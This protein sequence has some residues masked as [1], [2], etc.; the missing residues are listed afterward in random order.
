MSSTP[1]PSRRMPLTK[2]GAVVDRIEFTAARFKAKTAI[3]R[4][5]LQKCKAPDLRRGGAI[6]SQADG[7]VGLALLVCRS[8]SGPPPSWLSPNTLRQ[9]AHSRIDGGRRGLS[10]RAIICLQR[11]YFLMLSWFLLFLHTFLMCQPFASCTE[12]LLG[13]PEQPACMDGFVPILF[14][15]CRRPYALSYQKTKM[16]KEKCTVLYKI[17]SSRFFV[18][19]FY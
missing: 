19:L 5:C 4:N 13:G 7:V 10:G 18:I 2:V 14:L 17:F 11:C 1:S 16:N 12:T 3:R 15:L 6:L 8:E 9:R